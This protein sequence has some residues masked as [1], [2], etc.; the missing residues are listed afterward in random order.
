VNE[1]SK[2][3]LRLALEELRDG[4]A[5]VVF[6]RLDVV[7]DLEVAEVRQELEALG[8]TE[9]EFARFRVRARPELSIEAS[10]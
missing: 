5:P 3:L 7:T 2:R 1:F 8:A 9:S 6:A 4:P 10:E